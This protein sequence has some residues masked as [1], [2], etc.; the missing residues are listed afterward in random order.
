MVAIKRRKGFFLLF[1]LCIPVLLSS[2]Q[3]PPYGAIAYQILYPSGYSRDCYTWD[4]LT[5]I[6]GTD[7][8]LAENN[9]LEILDKEGGLIFEY[10][11]ISQGTVRGEATGEGTIWVCSEQWNSPHYN[12]YRSGNLVE[13]ILFLLDMETGDILF[14]QHLGSNELYLTSIGTK[15][16]FYFCGKEEEEKFFG[17]Y[18]VPAKNAEI[19]Y[20]DINNWAKEGSVYKFD[21]V[22]WPDNIDDKLSVENYIRFYLQDRI[23]TV[24]LTL[25]G[26]AGPESEEWEYIEKSRVE[27]PLDI[28]K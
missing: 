2:C 21:Y 25:Y 24:A 7:W 22:E 1:L 16:Y 17:L 10:P 13:S 5:P 12:G 27:I 18:K 15:C 26:K 20:R 11:D 19:Y 8:Y 3:Y 14:Q 6:E 4:K 28:K 9:G 23:I